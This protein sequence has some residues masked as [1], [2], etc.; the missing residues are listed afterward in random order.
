[1]FFFTYTSFFLALVCLAFATFIKMRKP[2]DY[3]ARYFVAFVYSVAVWIGSNA[4]ADIV[5]TPPSL[6]FWSG[7]AF[8]GVSFFVSFYLCFTYVFVKK[9]KPSR[10]IR[11]IYFLPAV[12][13][14]LG[15][16]TKLTTVDTIFPPGVPTLIIPGIFYQYHLIFYILSAIYGFYLLIRFAFKEA[17]HQE[18][19]QALFMGSGSF[20]LFAATVFFGNILPVFLNEL[21]FFNLGPQFSVFLI[22]LSSYAIV[23]H[24]LF[25]LQLLIKK[26][27]VFT[28]LFLFIL[29]FFNSPISLTSVLFPGI[30]SY[31]ITALVITVIFSPLKTWLENT[32][33]KIFFRRY[34]SF[35]DM[36]GLLN[37]ALEDVQ[38]PSDFSK[39]V[40]GFL[41]AVLK[42]E[43]QGFL[44]AD[45]QGMLK[46]QAPRSLGLKRV[47]LP[48]Q[49]AI[50]GHVT[51][52]IAS[53]HD[54]MQVFD[55]EDLD[56]RIR[57]EA[58]PEEERRSLTAIKEELV[59]LNYHSVV[60][61][62]NN[63]RIIGLLFL[64]PKLSGDILAES[65]FRIL[66]VLAHEGSI[67]LQ[68]AISSE[69]TLRLNELKSEFIRVVSHQ[70]RT[71]LSA[72]KW[73]TD[74]VLSQKLPRP[75]TAPMADIQINLSKI[76]DGLTS[77]LTVMEI[78]ED[79]IGLKKTNADLIEI[80]SSVIDNLAVYAAKKHIKIA[81]RFDATSLQA[82][83]D[84]EKIRKVLNILLMNAI[85]YSQIKSPVT[86]EITVA[87]DT[88]QVAIEDQGIGIPKKDREEVF[89][90]FFRGEEAKRLAPDGLGVN[91]YIARDF[92][93]RHGGNLWVE[94]RK[95][96]RSGTRIVFTLPL[97]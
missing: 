53:G 42:I 10:L 4:F 51:N 8:I 64:G 33:D 7:L 19:L 36:I 75:L 92:I 89:Q 48:S 84:V 6:I 44:I 67:T 39:K 3:M 71:P 32:T 57:Y 35:G 46:A 16:F 90:K 88:V 24:R 65:D 43:N 54:P 14:S 79:K 55:A 2:K 80:V 69:R 86:I 30:A 18:R 61:F 20:I 22:V 70:L 58:L 26:G 17:N 21:R 78:A 34:H 49:S 15:A 28:I 23:R 63:E 13:F 93:T 29:F 77:M 68:N 74:F 31:V 60:P 96:G 73:N 87:D 56:Y 85:M 45:E 50:I 9:K 41:R 52:L 38:T 76:S 40:S 91:M 11:A 62:I 5:K 82:T 83:F 12:V 95:D 81:K 59:H 72:A 1:M 94:D 47:T 27:A 37:K 97:Q 66:E 25:D